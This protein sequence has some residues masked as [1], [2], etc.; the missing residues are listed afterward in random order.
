MELTPNEL[1]IVLASI[2]ALGFVGV[3]G[4]FVNCLNARY[5]VLGLCIS[6]LAA[7]TS[8]ALALN[9]LAKL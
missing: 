8:M 3:G 6:G 7:A 1:R 2:G 4:I 5:E 9:A